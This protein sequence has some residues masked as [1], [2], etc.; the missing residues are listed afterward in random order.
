MGFGLGWWAQSQGADPGVRARTL[1][2]L[3]EEYFFPDSSFI[4]ESLQV[5]A[6]RG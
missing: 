5:Q 2:L 3:L 1:E 4:P 6:N